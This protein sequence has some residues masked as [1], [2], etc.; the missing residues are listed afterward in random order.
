MSDKPKIFT[1]RLVG[2]GKITIPIEIRQIWG[3]VN[4]DLVEL[5]VKSVRKKQ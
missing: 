3:I 2:N 1:S 5:E 4:D